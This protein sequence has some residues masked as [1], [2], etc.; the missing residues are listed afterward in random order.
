MIVYRWQIF[1]IIIVTKRV[2]KWYRLNLCTDGNV[3][4]S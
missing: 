3:E 1:L 4:H 2:L